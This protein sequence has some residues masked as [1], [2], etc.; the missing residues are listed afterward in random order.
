M[1]KD[2]INQRT[3]ARAAAFYVDLV[4]SGKN[5]DQFNLRYLFDVILISITHSDYVQNDFVSDNNKNIPE[6]PTA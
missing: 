6:D 2:L 3:H 5:L 1:T 4:V